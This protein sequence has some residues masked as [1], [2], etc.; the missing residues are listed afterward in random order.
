MGLASACTDEVM[1]TIQS[2][3]KGSMLPSGQD[4]VVT[5]KVEAD[6]ADVAGQTVKKGTRDVTVPE[7]DGLGFVVAKVP[8]E[9]LM[10]VRSYHQGDY[11]P[12][13]DFNTDTMSLYLGE[14]GLSGGTVSVASL[15]ADILAKAELEAFVEDPLYTQVSITIPLLGTTNVDVTINVTSVIPDTADMTFWYEGA[16]LHFQANLYDVPV[17]FTATAPSHNNLSCDGLADYAEVEITGQIDLET[18]A[19]VLT[20]IDSSTVG[21]DMTCAGLLTLSE[22]FPPVKALLDTEVPAA[23]ATASQNAADAVF[24]KLIAELRPSVSIHFTEPITL[25]TEVGDFTPGAGGIA[26]TYDTLIEAA[27]GTVADPT[28]GVLSRVASQDSGDSSGVVVSVGSGLINQFAFALWDAGNFEGLG[29]TAAELESMGMQ[30]LESPYDHL[31][32]VDMSLLLPPLLE[33]STDGP[34]LDI[35]GIEILI[36]V[37]SASNSTAWTAASVPVRLT[38]VGNDLQLERDPDR[39]VIIREVGFDKMSSL[40]DQDKV[41][42]LMET[43]VPGV[44]ATVFGELPTIVLNPISLSRLDGS[45]G[46][47]VAPQLVSVTER[48]DTWLLEVA[49]DTE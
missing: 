4:V 19:A 39:D 43:A 34:R 42:H 7:V 47:V 29:F 46:P 9:E 41:L 21:P 24:P 15:T 30:E 26:M 48:A 36:D 12:A 13:H 44:V 2:P 37:S 1:V 49:L 10:S 31:N 45:A 25:E 11:E 3:P 14:G 35:G 28:H 32:R 16:V 23:I 20:D 6:K 17:V 5:V 33:W 22:D 8:G 38:Q 40:A 27:T 18:G